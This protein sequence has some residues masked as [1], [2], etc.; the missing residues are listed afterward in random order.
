M[1]VL[2]HRAHAMSSLCCAVTWSK[3]HNAPRSCPYEPSCH[4]STD[5]RQCSH[6]IR[7]VSPLSPVPVIQHPPPLPPPISPLLPPS[8]I[9]LL[10]SLTSSAHLISPA[11]S[12]SVHFSMA[13]LRMK[14]EGGRGGGVECDRGWKGGEWGADSAECHAESDGR[15]GERENEPLL[16]QLICPCTG[17]CILPLLSPAPSTGCRSLSLSLSLSWSLVSWFPLS[18]SFPLSFALFLFLA[19]TPRPL[20]FSLPP[21]YHIPSPVPPYLLS[22]LSQWHVSASVCWCGEVSIRMYSFPLS[23][24]LSSSAAYSP[25]SSLSCSLVYWDQCKCSSTVP[26]RLVLKEVEIT[27]HSH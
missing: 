6:L 10:R 21:S 3:Q 24:P 1:L 7:H 18:L 19:P 8:P 25:S 27:V 15:E 5:V 2:V 23:S 11:L 22:F 14:G 16:S 20:S 9:P 12:P 17:Q 4:L 26:S 13:L